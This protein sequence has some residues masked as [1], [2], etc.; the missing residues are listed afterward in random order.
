MFGVV[1]QPVPGDNLGIIDQQPPKLDKV[2]VG[3]P[4]ILQS[5]VNELVQL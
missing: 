5:G 2:T 3:R 4:L 1:E